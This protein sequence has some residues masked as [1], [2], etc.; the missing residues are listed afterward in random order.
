MSLPSQY[1]PK[2]ERL[3][4]KI[5][6]QQVFEKGSSF[7][8]FPLKVVYNF[9]DET[10][11]SKQ[12]AHVQILISIPKKKIKKA[13]ERNQI[14]R[15]IRESYRLHKYALLQACQ[16]ENLYLHIAIIYLSNKKSSYHALDDKI[17]QSV[18]RLIDIVHAKTEKDKQ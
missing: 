15:K 7:K 5:D 9:V 8:Y 10:E 18:G 11:D 16:A 6:I 17:I 2:T 3:C 14:K 13:V 12:D 1:F 4:S